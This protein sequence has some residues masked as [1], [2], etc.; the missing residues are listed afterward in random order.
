M[1]GE[2]SLSTSLF[3]GEGKGEEKGVEGRLPAAAAAESM[4]GWNRW[5]KVPCHAFQ[6]CR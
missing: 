2:M 4:I 6:G 5:V 1:A 3:G